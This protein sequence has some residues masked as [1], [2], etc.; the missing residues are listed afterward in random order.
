[1][2]GI[3]V[4]W[5]KE[6]T[7]DEQ[8]GKFIGKLRIYIPM[9]KDGCLNREFRASQQLLGERLEKYWGERKDGHRFGNIR[10]LDDNLDILKD[11]LDKQLV[12]ALILITNTVESNRA[13]L[14]EAQMWSTN[15]TIQL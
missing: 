13:K 11:M 5:D 15:G 8:N 6:F 12:T 3:T 7:Y 1:M 9:D 4:K 14:H 10:L 2:L